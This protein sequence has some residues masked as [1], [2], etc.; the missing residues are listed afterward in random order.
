MPTALILGASRGL[1]QA[2]VEE[3]LR[4]GWDVI[5]TIRSDGA[6]SA[7]QR[8]AGDRLKIEKLDITDW[9]GAE[10]LCGRLEGQSLDLLFVNAGIA[11]DG[12]RIGD[13][14]PARFMEV[15]VVNA[16]APLRILDRFSNLLRPAGTLAVMSSSLASIA[17]NIG[18]GA[19]VYR[20][21]KA[22]LNM[23][24]RSIAARNTAPGRTY[25]AAAPG[26]VRTT[27]GGPDAPLSIQQSI[28]SLVDMLSRR[29]S[30]GGVHFVTYDDRTL[31][32]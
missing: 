10:A 18:G 6:L 16:L 5:A 11:D 22:A 12:A 26:W 29:H 8:E 20:M 27:M 13:V 15:L 4:R 30:N 24:L 25:I 1:G 14:E 28:P 17:D 19:E 3:Y 32:W 2:L 21:S 31:S 9:P 7:V 23:G